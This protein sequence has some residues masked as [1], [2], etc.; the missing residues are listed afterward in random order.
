MRKILLS[1]AF[2]AT[3]AGLLSFSS[4]KKQQNEFI[5]DASRNEQ[6]ISQDEQK[7]LD[8]IESFSEFKNGAKVQGDPLSVA[9]AC[10][11][12]ETMLNYCHSFTQSQLYNMR[13]D[14][15][16]VALPQ[17]DCNGNI[18][19][20]DFM[21]TY[22]TLVDAVRNTYLDINM[23]EKTLKFVRISVA[24]NNRNNEDNVRIVLNTGSDTA[25]TDTIKIE[26]W[27]GIPFHYGN[28]YLWGNIGYCDPRNTASAQINNAIQEYDMRHSLEY[29]SCPDCFTYI[30]NLSDSTYSAVDPSG[31]YKN[32]IFYIECDTYEELANYHI[33]WTDM[34]RYY[35]NYIKLGHYENMPPNVYGYDW[36]YYTSVRSSHYKD[37]EKDV[38]VGKHSVT[39]YNCTRHWRHHDDYPIPFTPEVPVD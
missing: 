17:T 32:N 20:N 28:C 18:S 26:P 27:Y 8:L 22:G 19:Y 35:A 15:V 3:I 14:T 24:D 10:E 7:I 34:N 21:Q 2:F 39:V 37:I 13:S 23:E 30:D 38:Y 16:F 6:G 25:V 29:V 12:M 5:S 36:Y 1:V 4:C 33:C 11:Q 31:Q 9:D